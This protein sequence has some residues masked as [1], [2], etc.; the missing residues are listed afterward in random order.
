MLLVVAIGLSFGPVLL[1]FLMAFGPSTI[2]AMPDSPRGRTMKRTIYGAMAALT[3]F[4][5]ASCF[6]LWLTSPYA[7]R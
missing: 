4:F 3:L 1:L 2:V 5:V 6:Y 7:G